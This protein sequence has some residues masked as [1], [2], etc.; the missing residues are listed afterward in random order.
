MPCTFCQVTSKLI[1]N[2]LEVCP[3]HRIFVRGRARRSR[4]DQG[5]LGVESLR[6]AGVYRQKSG[7]REPR[8]KGDMFCIRHS[9]RQNKIN[10]EL[11]SA[12][13]HVRQ[14]M[15]RVSWGEGRRQSNHFKFVQD[16]RRNE[17]ATKKQMARCYIHI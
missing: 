6:G 12:C 16:F 15:Y 9:A 11:H 8:L 5:S 4:G 2:S 10:H 17:R 3:L 7:V 13:P 1:S 14:R